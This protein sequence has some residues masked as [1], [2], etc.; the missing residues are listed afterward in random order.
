MKKWVLVIVFVSLSI[1]A[2]AQQDPI[3]LGVLL[4]T[5][6]PLTVFFMEEEPKKRSLWIWGSWTAGIAS[7][8]DGYRTG[9][10]STDLAERLRVSVGNTIDRREVYQ[11]ELT[12]AFAEHTLDLELVFLSPDLI[13][14][15]KPDFKR[16]DAQRIPYVVV[17]KEDA[18]LVTQSGL[19][20]TLAPYTMA[21]LR[22]Y[23][24][25]K[26]KR[27]LKEG[28][29]GFGTHNDDEDAA[30]DSADTFVSGYPR[31]VRTVS[32]TAYWRLSGRDVLHQL[33]KGTGFEDDFPSVKTLM[34]ANAKRFDF[35]RPKLKGWKMPKTRNSYLFIAEPKKDRQ[36]LAIV[37]D[38]DLL[39]KWLGQDFDSLK[40]YIAHRLT[41]LADQGFGVEAPTEVPLL[42][43]GESWISYMISNPKGGN[44]IFLHSQVE[45]LVLTHHIL[46]IEE[47]PLTM[48][49]K[50]QADIQNYVNNSV[51]QIK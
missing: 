48:L 14:K 10:R 2:Y 47:N 36:V 8:I 37:S 21:E 42:Q 13:V 46:V 18:G 26:K 38:V 11:R 20:G 49:T 27:T 41:Q 30:V 7:G 51:L 50:Y 28:L 45:N 6:A 5:S 17:L 29:R 4:D 35:E 34:D 40:P 31:A 24:V 39:V 19:W 12:A 33:A 16:I 43:F 32:N 22:V 23:D 44:S 15:G 9:A 25:R 1:S 3:K